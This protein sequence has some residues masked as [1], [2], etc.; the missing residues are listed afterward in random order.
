[1]CFSGGLL[2]LIIDVKDLQGHFKIP[3][4]E[5]LLNKDDY[6]RSLRGLLKE[7]NRV[8]RHDFNPLSIV[9]AL[10][11]ERKE[12]TI[13]LRD[14]EHRERVFL[15][16]ADLVCVCMLLS[17]SPQVR[18]AATQ[19]KRDVAVLRTFQA[20]VSNIQREAVGWLHDSALRVFRPNV[21]DFN[22]VLRKV[23]FLEQAEHYYKVSGV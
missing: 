11:E 13:A 19:S 10:L 4:Q 3:L 9:H 23:L 15:S 6:L 8:L 7:I 21:N 14:L 20:Q 22:H 12:V 5:L 16:L 17:V 2:K 18:D 1:M